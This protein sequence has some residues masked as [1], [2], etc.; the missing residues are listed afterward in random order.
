MN[1]QDQKEFYISATVLIVESVGVNTPK[2]FCLIYKLLICQIGCKRIRQHSKPEVLSKKS[3]SF[4]KCSEF[5]EDRDNII[6]SR[7][8][9]D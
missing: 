3:M 8:L 2:S 1:P 4:Q 9:I 6:S 5:S 7:Q